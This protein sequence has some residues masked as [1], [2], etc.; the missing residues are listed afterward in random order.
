MTSDPVRA[1]SYM[2]APFVDQMVLPGL[3]P[4]GR[5]LTIQQRFDEWIASDEGAYVYREVVRRALELV[6]R[7]W[8]HYSV[9][10]LIEAIRY[11]RSLA[12]GPTIAG[13][14]RIND[15][16]TSRLAR[17]AMAEHAELDGFFETRELRA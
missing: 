14:Y 2:R 5:V 16:Y 7:G 3:R 15:H 9:K 6:R 1:A 13:R 12:L 8:P 17:R 10:P 4:D 11:E